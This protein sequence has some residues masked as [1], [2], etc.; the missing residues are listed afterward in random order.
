MRQYACAGQPHH[1]NCRVNRLIIITWPSLKA[2]GQRLDLRLV[3]LDVSQVEELHQQIGGNNSYSVAVL[4]L[5]DKLEHPFE[6]LL[7][8]LLYDLSETP[9]PPL[10]IVTDFL[11]G[12]TQTLAI[13]N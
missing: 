11:L 7:H 8:C 3:E 1:L 13:L 9:P 12:W 10:C 2:E 6:N 5:N 4:V